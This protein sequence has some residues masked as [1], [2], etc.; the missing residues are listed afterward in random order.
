MLG[1]DYGP[2]SILTGYDNPPE[3]EPSRA[4]HLPLVAIPNLLKDGVT[5]DQI[6]LMTV[7]VPKRFLTGAPA[8]P[9][10]KLN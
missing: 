9:R 10:Q 8:L 1:H 3:E 7:E 4:T 6:R 2:Q 5:A